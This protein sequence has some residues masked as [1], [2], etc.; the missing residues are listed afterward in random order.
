M[1][2]GTGGT[3]TGST[4]APRRGII[5][6]LYADRL[7]LNDCDSARV[8]VTSSS[9]KE[10]CLYHSAHFFHVIESMLFVN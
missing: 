1:R 10:V 8:D 5:F 6:I 4:Y 2:C 7:K 9:R 3:N